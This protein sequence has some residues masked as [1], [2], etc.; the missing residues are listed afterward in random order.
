MFHLLDSTESTPNTST[1]SISTELSYDFK[2]T[3]A[4]G[5]SCM[6]SYSD[7]CVYSIGNTIYR[8]R[9]EIE[10]MYDTD[11][12]ILGLCYTGEVYF[13]ICKRYIVTYAVEEKIKLL[14]KFIPNI[15][16][17]RQCM[18]YVY[19]NDKYTL[20]DDK[21]LTLR[22]QHIYSLSCMGVSGITNFTITDK[23]LYSNNMLVKFIKHDKPVL[24][25][26]TKFTFFTGGTIILHG[27]DLYTVIVPFCVYEYQYTVVKSSIRTTK[28]S[29]VVLKMAN[30]KYV[31]IGSLASYSNVEVLPNYIYN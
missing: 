22:V 1:A 23:K 4:Y 10:K 25:D 19:I 20:T 2:K 27:D 14:Q 8:Y 9:T 28:C 15:D 29:K 24:P 17:V 7:E 26:F 31:I 18:N 13:A 16:S 11:E 3:I 12:P 5:V 30:K 6:I 21:V